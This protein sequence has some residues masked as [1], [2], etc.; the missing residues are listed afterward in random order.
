M[1][2]ADNSVTTLACEARALFCRQYD[3]YIV[4]T[5]SLCIIVTMLSRTVINGI[6]VLLCSYH[7]DVSEKVINDKY[8]K[9]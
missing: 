1:L 8:C 3:N 2:T 6:G 7:A 5:P 9:V 4:I